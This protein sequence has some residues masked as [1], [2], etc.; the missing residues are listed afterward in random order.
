MSMRITEDEEAKLI[1]NFSLEMV[2][3]LSLWFLFFDHFLFLCIRGYS[4]LLCVIVTSVVK[5][6]TTY[7]LNI[8]DCKPFQAVYSHESCPH[9]IISRAKLLV[10]NISNFTGP[11][12]EIW[13]I[14]TK[15]YVKVRSFFDDQKKQRLLSRTPQTELNSLSILTILKNTNWKVT[16]SKWP[17]LSKRKILLSFSFVLSVKVGI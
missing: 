2:N 16:T 12:E 13:L 15:N 3:S 1:L 7:K 4:H 6:T 11:I 8:E 17:S 9:K 10:D 14:L 5:K